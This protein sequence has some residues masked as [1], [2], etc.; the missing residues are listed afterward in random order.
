MTVDIRCRIEL[1]GDLRVGRLGS[2]D[3]DWAGQARGRW[4]EQCLGVMQQ[5]V[6][7]LEESGDWEQA[8]T[9]AWGIAPSDPD[10]EEVY[11]IQVRLQARLGRAASALETYQ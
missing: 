11:Q 3:E 10:R 7:L 5:R 4:S 9:A 1:L 2:C 8:L 6:T